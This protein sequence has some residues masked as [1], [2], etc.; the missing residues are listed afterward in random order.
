MTCKKKKNKKKNISVIT[1]PCANYPSAGSACNRHIRVPWLGCFPAPRL[2]RTVEVI[3]RG[4]TGWGCFA[5]PGCPSGCSSMHG[6]QLSSQPG[7]WGYTA[8]NLALAV[9]TRG[10]EEQ[11]TRR[12]LPFCK[13]QPGTP[14]KKILFPSVSL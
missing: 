12:R 2:H 10:A 6:A 11:K 4:A 14:Q 9:A 7:L 5:S 1:A 3:S 8:T 13:R